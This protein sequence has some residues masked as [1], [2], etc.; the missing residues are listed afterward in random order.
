VW[1]DEIAQDVVSVPAATPASE[2]P[3]AA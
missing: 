2:H 1:N 3:S